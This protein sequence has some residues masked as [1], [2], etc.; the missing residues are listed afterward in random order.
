M[1]GGGARASWPVVD[2]AC[3]GAGATTKEAAP[4]GESNAVGGGE[5]ARITVTCI[6]TK[7]NTKMG[8]KQKCC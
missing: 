1:T 2:A 8:A 7:K 5:G 6:G 3:V 4:A